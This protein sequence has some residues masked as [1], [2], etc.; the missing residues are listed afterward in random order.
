MHFWSRFLNHVAK[1]GKQP[2]TAP[3]LCAAA[4]KSVVPRAILDKPDH[5][6]GDAGIKKKSKNAWASENRKKQ[7]GDARASSQVQPR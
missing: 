4:V 7:L 6:G 5:A 2:I 3:V 1:D